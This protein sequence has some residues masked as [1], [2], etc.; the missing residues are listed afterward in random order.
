MLRVSPESNTL[1]YG[2]KS[3]G[4]SGLG[5]SEGLEG[6]LDDWP[7]VV[8]II[9]HFMSKVILVLRYYTK[10]RKLVMSF[11]LAE[12]FLHNLDPFAIEFPASWTAL[13]FVPQGIRWYG[14]SYIAG[15]ILAWLLFNWLV[16]T[17]RTT[18]PSR[19]SVA[20]LMFYIIIGVLVGGRLGYVL[21]YKPHLIWD[22]PIIGIFDLTGGG[23]ASHGGMIG[24][25]IACIIFAKRRGLSA[26]HLC[27]LAVLAA[28][29]GLSLG[30]FANFVNGELPGKVLPAAMQS[31]PASSP[32]VDPPWWGMK[33]PNEIY[34]WANH[35]LPDERILQVD[36]LRDIVKD[37]E[38]FYQNVVVALKEG[39]AQVVSAIEP[40][41]TTYYP[42]Q[43][44]Q[45]ITDGPILILAMILI[46]L[47]PRKPG[48]VGG[49]F[50]IVYGMLRI[51]SEL[52][53]E[54]D[55]GVALLFN[56]VSRGQLLSI[57][58]IICGIVVVI[59]S[60]RR[61]VKPLG[62]LL[63]PSCD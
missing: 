50:L 30:R 11:I 60:Q 24:V 19:D 26:L 53:R 32:L 56:A 31:Y 13:K 3:P 35:N 17:K 42:S 54:P 15:F 2:V 44:I 43:I 57:F 62:G 37:D 59:L 6:K 10:E 45:A 29:F 25:A 34:A 58:M 16:K 22:P 40:L 28:P 47:R 9:C 7:V 1:K 63:R 14:L 20:D 33:Y 21:F 61:E 18:L 48:V 52:F 5:N 23:M 46:W 49:G 38:Y 8:V 36:Q 55:A 39:N 27:D 4:E 12:A 41:L 51:F